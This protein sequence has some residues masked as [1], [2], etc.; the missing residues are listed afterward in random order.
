MDLQDLTD[1][2]GRIPFIYI[3][4]VETMHASSFIR[5]DTNLK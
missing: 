1:Y 5:Q 2:G 3:L 4:S